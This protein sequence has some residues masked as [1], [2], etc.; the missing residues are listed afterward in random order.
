MGRSRT[1]SRRQKELNTIKRQKLD[2]LRTDRMTAFVKAREILNSVPPSMRRFV[3]VH[4][5][6]VFINVIF[7]V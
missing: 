4:Y 6:V 2:V 1:R 7:I 3:H 5:I